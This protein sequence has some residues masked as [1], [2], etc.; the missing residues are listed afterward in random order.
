MK[1]IIVTLLVILMIDSAFS[2]KIILHR[3]SGGDQTFQ[4][5]SLDSIT[6]SP[7]TCGDEI[8]YERQTYHTVLIGTQCWMKENLN[9]G[10]PIDKATQQTNNGIIEKYCYNN[11]TANCPIFGG[12][13]QWNEA[14]QYITT[15]G[16][17]GICPTGWHIPTPAEFQLLMSSVNNDGNSLK[18][19]GQGSGAGAG[20]N[21]SGFS[22][23]LAGANYNGSFGGLSLETYFW[24]TDGKDICLYA[25]SAGI[26]VYSY[27]VSWGLSIRCIKD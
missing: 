18:Q 1:N 4:L 9:V 12:L 25:F 2:Q 7:F 11:D 23:L 15:S 20:T 8:R 26:D 16:A 21:S 22:A 24:Q 5:S 6:F 14:T 27:S 19:I 3:N 13:Y 17:Q 10:T